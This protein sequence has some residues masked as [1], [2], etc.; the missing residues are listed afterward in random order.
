MK[1]W[2]IRGI[3]IGLAGPACLVLAACSGGADAEPDIEAADVTE[4]DLPNM[5]LQV[6]FVEIDGVRLQL[7]PEEGG[8]LTREEM[9]EE[10]WDPDEAA[11]DIDRF[12]LEAHH[13]QT[14]LGSA[15]VRQPVFF[16]CTGLSLY[17]THEGATGDLSDSLQEVEAEIGTANPEG[18][19]L[20]KASRFDVDGLED[21]VGMKMTGQ[22]NTGDVFYSTWVSF[23]RGRVMGI[24]QVA[25]LDDRDLTSEA[26]RMASDLDRQ[27]ATVLEE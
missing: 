20:L 25:S 10:S 24:V 2:T 15:L 12:G 3:F 6:D 4:A 23:V 17:T 11:A 22:W 27:M 13:D 21:A 1:D 7:N 16:A 18:H 26:A 8:F 19:R 9:L 14:F 5:A